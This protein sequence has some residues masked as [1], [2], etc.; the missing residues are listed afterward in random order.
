MAMIQNK[1]TRKWQLQWNRMEF[2]KLNKLRGGGG[3]KN[4]QKIARYIMFSFPGMTVN[5]LSSVSNN[6]MRV[7]LRFQK[8][9]FNKTSTYSDAK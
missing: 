8:F 4:K 5:I 6:E 7:F 1:F 3:S 9:G 2:N